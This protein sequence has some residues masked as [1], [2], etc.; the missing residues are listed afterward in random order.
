MT[1]SQIK[2][3]KKGNRREFTQVY[4]GPSQIHTSSTQWFIFLTPIA[5]SKMFYESL[6]L[7]E[8]S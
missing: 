6:I 1:M 5:E 8:Y 2:G 3:R 7:S 4:R